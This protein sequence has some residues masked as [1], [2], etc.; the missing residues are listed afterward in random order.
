MR[1]HPASAVFDARAEAEQAAVDLRA[2]GV[3]DGAVQPPS[4]VGGRP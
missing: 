2:A 4:E 3:L 1:F